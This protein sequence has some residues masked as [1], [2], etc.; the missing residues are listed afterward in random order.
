MFLAVSMNDSP[1][2][3][4]EPPGEKSTVSA[5]SR[6]AARPKLVR[7]RVDGSKNRLA[8]TAPL[9]SSRFGLPP[10][11]TPT[12]VSAQVEDAIESGAIE[13]FEAEQIPKC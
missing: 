7:V 11:P 13:T 3:R 8:T 10:S 5:P 9:R 2:L 1:L 6:R 12:N 4:L